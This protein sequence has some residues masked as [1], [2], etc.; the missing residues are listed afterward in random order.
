[1]DKEIPDTIV[2]N[3]F[4]D[5]HSIRQNFKAGDK[6]SKQVMKNDFETVFI[7]FKNWMNSMHLKLNP[8]KTECILFRSTKQLE[9]ISTEPLISSGNL[10]PI[11]QIVRYLGGN[12]D[13]SLKF[14]EH[15]N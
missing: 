1:M 3:G 10:M 6:T 14:K 9:K 12:L 15:V 13:Q 8:D 7:H 4:V 5:D 2:I 11:S